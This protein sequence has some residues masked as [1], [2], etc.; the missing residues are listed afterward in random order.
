MRRHPPHLIHLNNKQRG[1]LQELVHDGRTEQRVARRARVLLA[2]AQKRTLV[3]K[4]AERLDMSPNGVW[5]LCRR[6]EERG[7]EAVWDKERSGRPRQFPP[8]VRVQV[9]QLACCEPSGLGLH[10]TH[11]STR[12]LAEMAAACGIVPHITQSTVSLILRAA[13]LE[14]HRCRYWKTPVL[15]PAFVQLASAVLWCYKRVNS[16]FERG[17]VVLCWDEKP[18]LQATAR[19]PRKAIIAGHPEKQEFEYTR[20]G[21]VNFATALDVQTGM[22]QAWCLERNDSEHLCKALADLFHFFRWARKIHLIW[23]NG[24][25]H[26]SHDTGQFL[27]GYKDRVQVLHTPAHASWL[28]QGELLLRAFSAWYLQRGSWSSI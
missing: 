27:R 5:Y 17:E 18:N 9:E 11:W 2:M 16:L 26:I 25:S 24:S 22:M 15:N 4:L 14:P 23:D 10:L 3:L 8:L 21:T 13:D 7:V 19:E 20:H 12:S 28:N 1:F 6:F